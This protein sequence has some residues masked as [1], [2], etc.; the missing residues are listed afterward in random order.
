MESGTTWAEESDENRYTTAD[1]S[2]EQW[3]KFEQE[4]ENRGQQEATIG[5]VDNNTYKSIFDLPRKFINYKDGLFVELSNTNGLDGKAFME[6]FSQFFSKFDTVNLYTIVMCT[7][8]KIF[9]LIVQAKIEANWFETLS[10]LK[11]YL[12][13]LIAIMPCGHKTIRNISDGSKMIEVLTNIK[14]NDLV[15]IYGDDKLAEPMSHM[16]VYINNPYTTVDFYGVVPKKP[17]INR[18]Q[19]E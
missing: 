16:N 10:T 4:I 18:Y 6:Q 12:T 11:I 19:C 8:N 15:A 5:I 14:P 7:N 17:Y 2:K 13:A 9:R 1:I 3:D